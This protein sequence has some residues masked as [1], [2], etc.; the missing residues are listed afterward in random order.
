MDLQVGFWKGHPEQM[1]VVR[2]MAP[3]WAQDLT[4]GNLQLR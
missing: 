4:V 2:K 3:P 1:M